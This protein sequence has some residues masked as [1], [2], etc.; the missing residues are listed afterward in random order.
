[1]PRRAAPDGK[2]LHQ[3]A[4]LPF[5]WT[6]TGEPEI[7]VLTSRETRRFV[8][9]KGWQPK[10]LNGWKA[11]LR[12]AKEEAGVDGKIGRK[13][14]GHYTYWKRLK[15]HFALVKVA[16]YPLEVKKHRKIWQEQ[17]ERAARWLS[18]AD[19]ALLVDEPELIAIFQD[20]CKQRR[21]IKR[22]HA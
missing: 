6:P 14:I 19:A 11:A 3:V 7:L 15:D 21:A 12:E 17:S 9:P 16:V 13:P 8:I 22:L 5:R 18:P 4:A 10:H 1:M 20:L 2:P